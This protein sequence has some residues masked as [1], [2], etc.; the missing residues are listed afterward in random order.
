LISP[1]C[2]APGQLSCTIELTGIIGIPENST[3]YPMAYRNNLLFTDVNSGL[4]RRLVLTD[5]SHAKAIFKAFRSRPFL[6]IVPALHFA[7]NT[8]QSPP[9]S[10]VE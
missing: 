4:I 6:S 7:E 5:M 8:L 2:G 1:P 3:A 10:V 9:L